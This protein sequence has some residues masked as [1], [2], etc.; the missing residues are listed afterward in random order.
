MRARE[1]TAAGRSAADVYRDRVVGGRGV[2]ALLVHELSALALEP[3]PGALGIVARRALYPFRLRRLGRGAVIGRNVVLRHPRRIS[4]GERVVIDDNCLLDGKGEG[5]GGLFV[6]D[7]VFVGRNSSLY[8]KGGRIEVGEGAVLGVGVVLNSSNR[9]VLEPGVQV[10][11]GSYLISGGA[12]DLD[13]PLAAALQDG[14]ASRGETRIGRGA[15]LG[16]NVTVTDGSRIGEGAVVGAG[17]VVSQEIP[18]GTLAMGVPA[19]VLRRTGA[20]A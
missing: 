12:Y 7:G 17:S 9:L 2:G 8:C 5:E 6:G 11:G 4:L 10:G 3:L 16:A 19:R 20:R 15:L 14:L 1:I 13:A 18:A